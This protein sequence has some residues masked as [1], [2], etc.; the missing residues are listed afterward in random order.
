M[1]PAD[2]YYQIVWDKFTTLSKCYNIFLYHL[3]LHLTNNFSVA[4]RFLFYRIATLGLL[5]PHY[6]C[7]PI[8]W[9][10]LCLHKLHLCLFQYCSYSLWRHSHED[11]HCCIC[12]LFGL[13]ISF[14]QVFR[15]N[16]AQNSVQVIYFR[17]AQ[18]VSS[19]DCTQNTADKIVKSEVCHAW[20][21]EDRQYAVKQSSQRKSVDR[22]KKR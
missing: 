10:A 9:H 18:I 14:E 17:N 7:D 13:F 5:W 15:G 21:R 4:L 3:Y 16:F 12:C 11:F 6:E 19:N 20:L 1:R 8:K 22:T 2:E